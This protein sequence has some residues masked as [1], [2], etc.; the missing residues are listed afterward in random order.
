MTRRLTRPG[1]LALAATVTLLVGCSPA[2]PDGAR[3]S[4]G[5]VELAVFA[6]ASLRDALA[7]VTTEYEA[8]SPGVRITLSTDAS[9]SLRAQIEQG[10]PADLFLSADQAEPEALVSAGLTDGPALTFAGNTLALIVPHDNPAR[11]TGP[12]DLA[13][14]GLKIVAAGDKVPITAYARQV[15]ARLASLPGY[16]AGFAAD[17]DANVVSR[18]Q[19]VRAVLARIELGEAD[20]ALVYRTDGLASHLVQMVELPAQAAVQVAYAGVVLKSSSEP[21]AARAFLDWLAGPAGTMVLA[22]F[23]FLAP[24]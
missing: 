24:R 20:A 19:N 5:A 15:V 21:V 3:A 2:G 18:E 4:A 6:A 8:T 22:G 16:P 7:A 12:R 1:I 10:A 11:L 23:G 13:R 14:P 9:S 17:Y